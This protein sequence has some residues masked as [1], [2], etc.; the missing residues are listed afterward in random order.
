MIAVSEK[1]LIVMMLA[2]GVAE[3]LRKGK[4]KER[5]VAGVEM[6]MTGVAGGT[7]RMIVE[8]GDAVMIV[9][10]GVERMI[11]CEVTVARVTMTIAA[12]DAV[13]KEKMTT[14][15]GV[16]VTVAAAVK[17]KMMMIVVDVE[18]GTASLALVKIR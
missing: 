11:V 12:V 7:T 5:A 16:D 8:G 6:G 2:A 17:V 10:A 4:K 1:I 3:M 14:V 9:E 18:E 15:A 13:L